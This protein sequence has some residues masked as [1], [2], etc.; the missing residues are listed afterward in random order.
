VKKVL[1]VCAVNAARS[2]M[3]GVLL[4]RELGNGYAVE[5][6]GTEQSAIG[7]PADNLAIA[8]MKERGLDISNHRG[9]WIGDIDLNPFSYIVCVNWKVKQA[10][11]EFP[12]AAEILI[13]G[14]RGVPLLPG[15]GLKEFQECAEFL[16]KVIPEI[17]K[18]IRG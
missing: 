14:E 1:C 8:C 11:A 15:G 2:V 16:D 10:V 7:H 12:N 17:A 9:R 13:P 4:Q 18:T 5:S 3:M 6:A